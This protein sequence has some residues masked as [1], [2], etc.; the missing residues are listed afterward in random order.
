MTRRIKTSFTHGFNIF[1]II[2]VMKSKRYLVL[3]YQRSRSLFES[4]LGSYQASLTSWV[5]G[6]LRYLSFDHVDGIPNSDID[7]HE[8]STGNQCLCTEDVIDA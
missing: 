5:H 2:R 4:A 6:S 3:T 8:R 1:I 7:V